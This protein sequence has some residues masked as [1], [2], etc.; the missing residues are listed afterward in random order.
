MRCT[1]CTAKTNA[2]LTPAL[3]IV[4]HLERG[5]P[6]QMMMKM[7]RGRRRVKMMMRM[8]TT[9]VHEDDDGDKS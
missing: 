3:A 7:I 1:C 2:I 8:T 9:M 4:W 6:Q 5:K